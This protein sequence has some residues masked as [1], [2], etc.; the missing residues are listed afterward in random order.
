VQVRAWNY[1]RGAWEPVREVATET[2]SLGERVP[3]Y[4]WE[5]TP[6]WLGKRYWGPSAAPCGQSG[7]GRLQVMERMGSSWF[8]L[9]TFTEEG[10]DCLGREIFE[11]ADPYDAGARCYTGESVRMPSPSACVS[12][13]A[14]DSTPPALVVRATDDDRA[15]EVR[16]GTAPVTATIPRGRTLRVRADAF[17]PQGPRRLGLSF[18]LAAICAQ[19]DVGQARFVD[20]VVSATQS[21]VVGASVD[22]ALGAVRD[23]SLSEFQ[24]L[25]APGFTLESASIDLTATASSGAPSAAQTP[26]MRF[27]LQI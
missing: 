17:D 4:F 3:L 7:E 11:G 27:T 9:K 23:V 26:L 24:A 18:G 15:W 13:P 20:G 21:A 2:S 16:V 10:L 12:V 8:T 25:C 6:L 1:D 14:T 19:G 5:A 22:A